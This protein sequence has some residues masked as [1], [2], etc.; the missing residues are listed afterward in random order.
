MN[1]L[2]WPPLPETDHHV[3]FDGGKTWH[4]RPGTP[5]LEKVEA[6]QLKPESKTVMSDSTRG[7]NPT[8]ANP[9][10]V[11]WG[12]PRPTLDPQAL[13]D[14]AT[15]INNPAPAAQPSAAMQSIQGILGK[16]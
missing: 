15:V 14:A 4:I 13:S 1:V 8:P 7:L 12:G 3:T 5:P 6:V 2:P 11:P 10:Q 9:Q 16:R